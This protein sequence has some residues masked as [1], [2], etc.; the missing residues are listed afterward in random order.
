MCYNIYTLTHRFFYFHEVRTMK[1]NK[2][3]YRPK[4]QITTAQY[5][6]IKR[7][8]EADALVDGCRQGIAAVLYVLA[9]RETDGYNTEQLKKL[10]S[11][12]D[13]LLT[14]PGIMGKS[15]YG[16]DLIDYLKN[17]HDVDVD[18]LPV[19]ADPE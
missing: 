11:D 5:N 10:A 2:E 1:A 17:H 9:T 7:E 18:K 8:V 19:K 15:F 4:I 6:A 12:V 14:M 16:Q 13:S 3:R